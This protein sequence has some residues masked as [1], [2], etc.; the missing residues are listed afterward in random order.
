[1][2]LDRQQLRDL[3]LGNEA[4][5]REVMDVLL[6]DTRKQEPLLERAILREDGQ[7]VRR[8]AH[9]CR[10]ACDGVGARSSADLLHEMERHAERGE[11]TACRQLLAAL[12]VELYRLEEEAALTRPV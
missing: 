11:F 3:T 8:L 9:Y 2:V 12:E 4:L 1:M 5:M 7:E 10:G 6:E